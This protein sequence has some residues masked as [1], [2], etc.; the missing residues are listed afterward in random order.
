M[1]LR[2]D[3]EYIP[4]ASS[5]LVLSQAAKRELLGRI[6]YLEFLKEHVGVDD[7]LL[8]LYRRWGMSFWMNGVRL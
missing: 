6:S 8:E 5:R 7:Q 3:T 1:I 2:S 4:Q